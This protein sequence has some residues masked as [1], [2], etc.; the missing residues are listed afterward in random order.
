MTKREDI[1][2]DLGG[3]GFSCVYDAEYGPNVNADA[4]AL[5]A[6]YPRL[7]QRHGTGIWCTAPGLTLV[8]AFRNMSRADGDPREIAA[9]IAEHFSDASIIALT[10]AFGV[11][12]AAQHI[13]DSV[14]GNEP[15]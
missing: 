8:A 1:W 13:F 2:V 11:A 4:A 14:K 10:D 15:I 3:R 5:F 12:D 7:I 6:L 9:H